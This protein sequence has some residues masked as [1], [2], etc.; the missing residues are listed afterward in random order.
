MAI[1]YARKIFKKKAKNSFCILFQYITEALSLIQ[2][3]SRLSTI[4]HHDKQFD[5]IFK[6]VKCFKLI[7]DLY[8]YYYCCLLN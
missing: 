4:L 8:H 1:S 7:S 6:I 5:Q 2:G 3:K